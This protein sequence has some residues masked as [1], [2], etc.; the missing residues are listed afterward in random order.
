MAKMYFKYSTVAAGKSLDLLKTADAYMRRGRRVLIMSVSNGER[1]NHGEKVTT[2]LGLEAPSVPITEETNPLAIALDVKP[3]IVLVDEAQFLSPLQVEQLTDIVD[4][5]NKPVIAYGI[6]STFAA[7]LFAGSAALLAL[8]DKIEEIKSVCEICGDKATMNL[9]VVNGQITA[10]GDTVMNEDD[11]V[12]YMSVCRKHF[13]E[14][15][16][17]AMTTEQ[18]T[19]NTSEE[20]PMTEEVTEAAEES[21]PE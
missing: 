18:P 1:N 17:S 11:D 12:R 6:K 20:Q 5:L 8:A 4:Q 15:F 19:E 3:D 14:G 9:R 21:S 10:H 7:G 16:L 13:K 2:R